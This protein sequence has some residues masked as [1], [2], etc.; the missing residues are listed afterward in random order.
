VRLLQ[1][2]LPRGLN[3]SA[4]VSIVVVHRPVTPW[5]FAAARVPL[6]ISGGSKV[7]RATTV[8]RPW[9]RG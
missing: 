8:G 7:N 6:P 1:D 3:E 2:G 9:P 5:V 4:L